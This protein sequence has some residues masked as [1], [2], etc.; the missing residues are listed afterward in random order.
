MGEEA[1]R[2]C[3]KIINVG[4]SLPTPSDVPGMQRVET[5]YAYRKNILPRLMEFN[6]DLIFVSAGFDAHKRDEMNFGYV[7]M[8]EEDY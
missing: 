5:R 8:V 2:G 1:S 3:C 6:P 4:L 7:V